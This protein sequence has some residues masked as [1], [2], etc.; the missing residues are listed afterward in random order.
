MHQTVSRILIT[1]PYQECPTSGGN[2]GTDAN[3]IISPEF[4][5]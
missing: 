4:L 2:P 1:Q 5:K 3:E